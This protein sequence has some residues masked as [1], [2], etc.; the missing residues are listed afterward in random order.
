MTHR[1]LDLLAVNAKLE[2]G[3]RAALDL[4][5]SVPCTSLAISR[6]EDPCLW[7]GAQKSLARLLAEVADGQQKK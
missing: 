1:E 4:M 3:L 7:C 2:A 6:P 5:A